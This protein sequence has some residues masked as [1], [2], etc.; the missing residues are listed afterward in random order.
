MNFRVTATVEK[1]S[2]T[3]VK[4]PYTLYCGQFNADEYEP[5]TALE[6]TT[7]RTK[8]LH[9]NTAQVRFEFEDLPDPRSIH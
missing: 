1:I 8:E 3:G 5:A 2:A 6:F 7:Q 9:P 4:Y